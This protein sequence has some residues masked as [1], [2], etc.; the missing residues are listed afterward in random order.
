[1]GHV[2]FTLD[3][4]E[5]APILLPHIKAKFPDMGHGVMTIEDGNV[6]FAFEM[7]LAAET[8][9][10]PSSPSIKEKV[11]DLRDSGKDVKEI[12]EELGMDWK[13]V[14]GMLAG[15]KG[16]AI[17][18]PPAPLSEED[19][20]KVLADL[21]AKAEK[22]FAD[23]MSIE[24]I[25]DSAI[26]DHPTF[27]PSSLQERLTKKFGCNDGKTS[28]ERD[29]K[30]LH[31]IGCSNS[32]IKQRLGMENAKLIREVVKADVKR[33]IAAEQAH[34]ADMSLPA[35]TVRRILTL[36]DEKLTPKAISDVLEEELGLVVSV[37]EIMDVITKHAK[38]MIS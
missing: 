13:K 3:K 19:L 6:K 30:H 18:N 21:D 2:E 27:R 22:Q 25:I 9:N 7:S 4:D 26:E 34:D 20:K 31:E 28:L 32:E 35:A 14:R 8:P 12:G 11:F 5:L 17:E 38:G 15:R 1:M 33:E 10:L 37:P 23:G 36:D 24:K 16:K 29:I